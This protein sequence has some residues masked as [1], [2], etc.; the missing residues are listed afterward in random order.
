MV[1]R[2]LGQ[3]RGMECLRRRG[4]RVVGVLFIIVFMIIVFMIMVVM[5]MFAVI[6][7]A[8]IVGVV[9]MFVM[10]MV[11]IVMM[12]MAVVIIAV[13]GVGVVMSDVVMR[14]AVIVCRVRFRVWL[15]LEQRLALE[16]LGRPGRVGFRAFDEFALNAL[17]AAA[18]ARTA[19]ARPPAVGTVFALFLG[20]AMGA[21]VGLDQGL[22]VGDRDLII[23][24]MDFAEGQKT[25]AVAAILDE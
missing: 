6:V 2:G 25:M 11:I 21:L 10:V 22:T 13:L 20:L 12:I 1:R 3:H 18:A 19:V 8:V 17:V 24:G 23:I 4:K 5:I 16:R 15:A 14:R 7:P 9:R